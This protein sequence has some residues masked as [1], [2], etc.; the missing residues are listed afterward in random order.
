M[1]E[2]IGYISLGAAVLFAALLGLT[3]LV[4]LTK[5]SLK[6]RKQ[7]IARRRFYGIVA[8]AFLVLGLF[9]LL[10]S[11]E[12]ESWRLFIDDSSPVE[13]Y[14]AAEKE[15]ALDTLP[16]R[17]FAL[18]DDYYVRNAQGSVYG[19]VVTTADP[20]AE[21]A[22]E[23]EREKDEKKE[24]KK[25][26]ASYKKGLCCIETKQVSGGGNFLAVLNQAGELRLNGAFEYLTYEDDE[27]AFEDLL[28]AENCTFVE[29]TANELFYIVDGE[30]YSAGYN[31]FGKLGDGTERNRLE[32]ASILKNVASVSASETHTLAVD[33]YGNLYGFG[34]NSYSEMGNR[35]TASST[36]PEKLMGGVKQAEAGRYFSVVLT[37]NGEVY[38]AGRNDKGQLGTGDDRSYATFM[39]ILDGVM[40][41]SVCGDSCAALTDKGVLYVWGS[42]AA[43]QLGAGE[44]K[45]LKPTE[46]A[47]D[48]YD[49]SMGERSMGVIK[50]NR[51]VAVTGMARP[52]QNNEFQQYLY[53]FKATVPEAD[54]YQETVELPEKNEKKQK[55]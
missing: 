54:R 39:K 27:T 6:V 4:K 21:E 23:K 31:R 20:A 29:A 14:K 24:D 50:L 47:K 17:I 19:Y 43:K 41:I 8:G 32:G 53:Q 30:L 49:V 16:D 25:E 12:E 45:L 40:K 42:N 11:G 38:V 10:I 36:I 26:K 5:K 37:K 1:L 9:F 33:V 22:E 28:F 46:F 18:G 34:D 35:T 15:E 44:A 48:V 13:A 2:W 3:F 51:D 7:L 55:K 52:K